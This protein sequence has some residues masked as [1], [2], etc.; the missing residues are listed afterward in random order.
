MKLSKFIHNMVWIIHWHYFLAFLNVK[1]NKTI[2]ENS[3]SIIYLQVHKPIW[4]CSCNIFSGRDCRS[5]AR[6]YIR[7]PG[8]LPQ[9]G[10]SISRNKAGLRSGVIWPKTWSSVV[11]SVK[12]MKFDSTC[13]PGGINNC[14]HLVSAAPSSMPSFCTLSLP[15]CSITTC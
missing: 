15:L 1:W 7:N 14:G 3:M 11:H 9:T 13:W 12:P 10:R 6:F 4:S 5:L 8:C 2:C